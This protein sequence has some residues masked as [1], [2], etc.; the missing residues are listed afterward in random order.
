MLIVMENRDVKH[1]LEPRLNLK[2]FRS[3]NIFKI[4]ASESGGNLCANFNKFLGVFLI[5]LYV[6]HINVCE[7][8]EKKSL[9]LHN[10]LACQSSY[11]TKSQYSCTV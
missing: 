5:D 1:L 9:P 10:R 4:D 8:L 7:D 6:K 11:V 3:F 2:A